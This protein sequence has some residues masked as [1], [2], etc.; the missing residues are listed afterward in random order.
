[1][2]NW[3]TTLLGLFSIASVIMSAVQLMIDGDPKTNPDWN[4]VFA[5]CSAGVGLILAREQ[6][7]HEK[8]HTQPK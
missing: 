5:Q 4:L 2:K 6:R 8:E 1:M 3:R 7:E